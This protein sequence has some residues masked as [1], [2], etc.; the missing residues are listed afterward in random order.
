M[1]GR[2]LGL[3]VKNTDSL[4]ASLMLESIVSLQYLSTRQ[5]DYLPEQ[6]AIKVSDELKGGRSWNPHKY[7]HNSE[8]TIPELGNKPINTNI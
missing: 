1:E 6:P 5:S 4:R 2:G 3:A 8:T 7:S